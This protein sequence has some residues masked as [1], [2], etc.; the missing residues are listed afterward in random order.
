MLR[1]IGLRSIL[2][3]A[4]VV[5]VLT[6]Q[7]SGVAGAPPQWSREWPR[8]DFSKA[9]VPLDEIVSGGVPKDG[10][11]AIDNP[12]FLSAAE[13]HALSPHEPV[14][15]VHFHGAV[16][17]YPLRIL[18]WHE[19]V[20][21][22]LNGMPIAVTFCPLCNSAVVFD[23]RVDGR[24]LSFGTTGRLR[25]SD[26]VMYDRQTESWWQQF[27]GEAIVGELVGKQLPLM[28]SRVESFERF[29]ERYPNGHVLV[30]PKGSERP[31]GTNPYGGYDR[32]DKPPFFHG[33]YGDP[34][35][36]LARVVVVGDQAWTL[37]LLM[38]RHKIEADDLVVTWEPGQSSALDAA[39]IEAGRD[40]GNVVV[41]RR[42]PQGM[43][44]AVYDVSFAFAFRAFHPNGTLRWE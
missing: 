13:T 41:Q 35:P 9:S 12:E 19:I 21:D 7:I 2:R 43:Q 6:V 8:T 37:D 27:L 15:S 11:P 26:L 39:T 4:A 24:V 33:R 10:I 17:A 1:A 30:P 38:K 5:A 25:H 20:N 42:T 16:R 31:Y 34:V 22:S 40:I 32:A 28:A 44:D 23:R 36:P 29:A 14:I 3:E 18:I